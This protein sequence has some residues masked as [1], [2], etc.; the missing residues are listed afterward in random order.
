MRTFVELSSEARKELI[1][2]LRGAPPATHSKGLAGVVAK[3]LGASEAD[4]LD[5]ANLLTSMYAL[6]INLDVAPEEFAATVAA[7]V[8]RVPEMP[9]EESD[10]L[11]ADLALIP[12]LNESI[13]V[14]YKSV[15][16]LR[17]Y[18]RI[19]CHGRIL[20]DI[21]PLFAKDDPGKI[22]GAVVVHNLMIHHK[23]QSEGVFFVALDRL[24]LLELQEMVERALE[25]QASIIALCGSSLKILDDGGADA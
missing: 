17:E 4:A 23:G 15:D 25:K 2:A 22:D 16:V 8:K 13:G 12:Q 9:T 21:R 24:D 20:T 3:T 14:L 1:K 7:A 5:L 11:V 10:A 6:Y 19:W 18:E